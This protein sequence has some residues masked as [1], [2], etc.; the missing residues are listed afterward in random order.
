MPIALQLTNG[1]MVLIVYIKLYK[2]HPNLF[3]IYVIHGCMPLWSICCYLLYVH[4]RIFLSLFACKAKGGEFRRTK[5][6]QQTNLQTYSY[7][8]MDWQRRMP[9]HFVWNYMLL[10]STGLWLV[11]RLYE[12][13]NFDLW[14]ILYDFLF[15]LLVYSNFVFLFN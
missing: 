1:T 13:G 15:L 12:G 11:V 3:I 5:L 4:M 14:T 8:A 6:A 10:L 2:F 9:L 7:I